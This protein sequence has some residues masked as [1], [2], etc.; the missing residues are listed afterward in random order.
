MP[1]VINGTTG[2]TTDAINATSGNTSLT[3]L[4]VA[5][6]AIS[7]VNSLGFRNRLING[8]MSI[9]QRNGGASVTPTATAYT[10]DRWQVGISQASK[11]SVEQ[12]I[13]GVAAPT[14]FTDYLGVTSTSAYSVL[15]S[16]FFIL[17]QNIEGFNA[18]DFGW[19]TA[20]ARTVTLSFWVRSSLT[21][22]FGGAFVNS[23]QNRS[24]P[25]T[26]TISTANTWEQ[27]TITVAGDTSGTWLTNNDVGIR[28]RFGLGVG[29]T[30]S[31][32][33][34]A[35]AGSNFL[36]AT[37]AVSVVGTNG[38]TLYITGVQLEAGTVATPFERLPYGTEL[39]LCQRY[40]EELTSNAFNNNMGEGGSYPD[41]G[42]SIS[43]QV[44]AYFKVPKR[45][46]PTVTLSAAS[47]FSLHA[48]GLFRSTLTSISINFSGTNA[49]ALVMNTS[50]TT[51]YP[52]AAS[53]LEGSGSGT[54]KI[55]FSAEL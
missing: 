45:A 55:M 1:T 10:L 3:T 31:G 4:N 30:I 32:T 9:D 19:G 41:V 46:Q 44:N 6:N 5:S 49:V 36:S 51:T 33:A 50:G 34:G 18:S 16:D 7:A 54:A 14:G 2:I 22:T 43:A 12:T 28:V 37:G 24:Y 40:Y 48:P 13:A 15:T 42:P 35:W 52:G 47:T 8:D 25:F 26:Y 17:E 27:K 53:F 23:A 38:A 39:M 29:S 11:F 21:G 20:G